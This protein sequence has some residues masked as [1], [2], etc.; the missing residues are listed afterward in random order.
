[1]Q[2]RC[3]QRCRCEQSRGK[4][5][6]SDIIVNKCA[7]AMIFDVCM[8]MC[9]NIFDNCECSRKMYC[10]MFGGVIYLNINFSLRTSSFDLRVHFQFLYSTFFLCLRFPL[11]LRNA[12]PR[13]RMDKARNDKDRAPRWAPKCSSK[14]FCL[15]CEMSLL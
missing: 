4:M 1:M 8:Y 13:C 9:V 14:L 12:F 6:S 2:Q 3:R 15:R 5:M 11:L 10:L 7:I